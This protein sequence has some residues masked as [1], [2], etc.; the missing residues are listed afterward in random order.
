MHPSS[1]KAVKRLSEFVFYRIFDMPAKL[2]GTVFMVSVIAALAG[3]L[4]GFDTGIISGALLFIQDQFPLTTAQKEIVVS[5]VIIGAMIGSFGSG[6][7][8]DHFGRRRVMLIIAILFIAGTLIASFAHSPT[9]IIFGRIIIGLAIGVGSYTAPLYIAEA[10]PLEWRGALVTLNQLAITLGI[11]SAYVINFVFVDV[12]GSWRWMFL[13]GIIPAILL[14]IGMIFLPESPRWL[15]KQNLKEKARRTLQYLR[16]H[17]DVDHELREIEQSLLLKQA[18]FK[19]IFAPWIRRVLF[20]GIFLGFLQQVSGIN[21]IIY[22]APTIFSMVGFK[23][24]S[25]AILA[26]V[27]V[28]TVNVLS[29]LFAI[30]VIDKL[31]RR[32]LL[33]AGLIGMGISLLVLSFIFYF[34]TA[35]L[36]YLRYIAMLAI[37]VYIISF[38]FSL[39]GLLW[40]MLS[41]IFPLEVR[42]TAMSFAVFTSWFWNFLVSFTFLTLIDYLGPAGTFLIYA[43]VCAVGL[44]IS[45]F[46]VPETKNVSLEKIEANIRS[47]LA[48]RNIG[49]IDYG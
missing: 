10:A 35:S 43:S 31:G 47:D 29:T 48:L 49:D 6:R 15:V 41:E 30:F 2:N 26:T 37:F 27:G 28:G 32:P 5:S 17:K 19:E 3:L 11:F 40:L 4:F 34:E 21:A 44:V 18:P 45:Y 46:Y 12:A 38:A 23:T 20:L 16:A 7:L 1:F 25:G 39:G 24:T 42:G 14:G 9:I 13:I 33:F 22:Y 36:G 8:T